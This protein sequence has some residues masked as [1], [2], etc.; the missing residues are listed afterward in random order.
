MEGNFT[1]LFL[2]FFPM[3][4]GILSY[5]IGRFNKRARDYFAILIT[6][7]EFIVIIGFFPYI[8]N[9]LETS[10]TWVD[11]AGLG[12]EFTL[13]GFR[14]IYGIITIFMWLGTTIFSVEYFKSYRNRNRYYLFMLITLGATLGVLFSV[15]FI[16]TFIMFEIMSFASYVMVIHDEKVKSIKSADT[17]I[18]VSLIGGM[19]MLIG[20][21]LIQHHLG[22]THFLEIS[23]VME[24]FNGDIRSIYTAAILMMVGFGSKAGMFPIH[25][26]LPNAHPSA[27]APASALLSGILTKTGIFGAAVISSNLFLY[28]EVW[29]KGI[30]VFGLITMFIG[31]FFAL[32]SI[33]IKR[34]LAYSSVSQI[35]FILVGLAMEGILGEHNA[36]AIRGALLHMVNHS[37]IKL[38]LFMAA[39]VV[40][41]NLHDLNLNKIRGFGRGKPL[42]L[43]IFSM[44]GLSL[45]GM[46]FW[47]GFISK[48]LLHES[49]VEHIWMFTEY[50][51]EVRFF[52]FAEGLFMLT[53]GLTTAYMI[54]LFVV[55]FIDKNPDTQDVNDSFN[56]RYM[57]RLST[58]GL[59][60]P[61]ILLFVLGT[62][63][64]I[65]DSIG[66]LGQ[67]FFFGHDPSH[68]VHYFSW[69]NVKGAVISI[70]IGIIV[71]FLVIRNF[72]MEG[73]GD[74]DLEYINPWPKN[75]NLEE[76]I[77]KPILSDIL[78]NIGG[79]I[80]NN[81]GNL[82]ERIAYVELGIFKVVDNL[83]TRHLSIHDEEKEPNKLLRLLEAIMPNTMASSLL[84]FTIGLVAILLL[85][86]LL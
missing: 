33:D 43:F 29:G 14:F 62:F 27:P 32:F 3:V 12:L 54:K 34:I 46:P 42:F 55:L 57:T 70:S 78:P 5:I 31:A 39:G 65:M 59:I 30:M 56:G 2:V 19:V 26:W 41:M 79:F 52:Q 18:A 22:T 71:Y 48:T 75:L 67:E 73:N 24:D 21:M 8:T 84:Q 77:Y 15:D 20:I 60:V 74:D 47:S 35:G 61:A 53:G 16:T 6:L 10:V 69:I 72:L 64:S 45:I 50:N 23:Q 1:L 66:K 37:L 44:G 51:M 25:I 7:M 80:A 38:V 49:I 11:F 36:L 58:V 9:N 17:Y 85:V 83:Y 76:G 82:V 4:G 86:I 28:D 68:E 81:L 63:P 40:Y 13:D